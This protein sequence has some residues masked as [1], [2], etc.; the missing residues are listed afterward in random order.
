MSKPLES[1]RVLEVAGWTFVPV[2][3]AMM[4]EMGAEVIKVEP[5]SGDPQRALTNLLNFETHGPNPFIE[6]PNRGKK[7][8]TIDL[9]TD[10]GREVLLK[11]AEKS[12]VFLTSYL[13]KARKKLR[14]DVD[15]IRAVNPNIIYTRGTGWGPNGPM[16]N[17]A[18]YDGVSA[19]AA[20][21]FAEHL[22]RGEPEGP[23]GQPAAFFDLQGG[24]TI[25]G[26]I[27]HALFKRERTGEPSIIDVSL[28][29]VGMWAMS[30]NITGAP[31]VEA[32]T[33]YNRFAPGNPISNFYRTRDQRWL[34][35]NCLQGDRFWAEFCEAVGRP[36]MIDDERFN[37]NPLR[38]K[39]SAACVAEFDK[40]FATKTFDE[41][42][43]VFADFTGAW[44]PAFNSREVHDHPQVA[45][46]NYLSPLISHDGVDFSVV[47]GAMQFDGEALRTDDPAPEPGQHT[48]TLLMDSG[49]EWE[50]I[51]SLRER[52]AF[53]S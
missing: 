15:D 44:S 37:T 49:L 48:E 47:T 18:G 34:Y 31:F 12:D 30:Y 23:P 43:E 40:I 11:L 8:I 35:F 13:E 9:A 24:N 36:D 5:P 2:A 46:N 16:R 29:N 3:G 51:E 25:A 6:I 27:G 22:N 17:D 41:W 33:V 7:S 4:A 38:G 39:N 52:G 28:M 53:G 42:L 50:E 26:A 14:I 10:A 45:A 21:G 20:A 32:D 1:V 19:W